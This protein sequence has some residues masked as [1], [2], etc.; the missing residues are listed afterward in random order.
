MSDPTDRCPVCGCAW[1]TGEAKH[2]DHAHDEVQSLVATVSELGAERD[3]LIDAVHKHRSR[4][5]GNGGDPRVWDLDLWRIADDIA[6]GTPR[7]LA[8]KE[9]G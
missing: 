5:R 1:G 2:L 7:Q 8:A 3:A 4:L 9:Q 6:G